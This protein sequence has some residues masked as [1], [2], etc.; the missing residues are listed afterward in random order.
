VT[1]RRALAWTVA[2]ALPIAL[3]AASC[4][5]VPPVAPPQPPPQRPAP[6]PTPAPRET[7]PPAPQAQPAFRLDGEPEIEV[8]IGVDQDRVRI[9]PIRTVR[10]SKGVVTS[11]DELGRTSAPFEARTTGSQWVLVWDRAA[12]THLSRDD[13]LWIDDIHASGNEP[14]RADL[15]W[16]GHTWRG[17]FKLFM[18]PRGR[19][20]LVTRLP[21]ESYLIG[22]I[23]GEIGALDERLLDAGRAQAIA[24]R[25]YTLY[26]RGRRGVE[27]FDVYGTVLDQVYGP[28]E[29]EAPAA[30]RCVDD[31]RGEVA[32]YD[33][34]PI[35]ANYCSTC[36]GITAEVWEAWP[37]SGK[38]YLTSHRDWDGVNDYCAVSRHY[39]W[40][41]VWPARLFLNTIERYGPPEGVRMP[42][43]GAGELR[44][45]KVA[46]RSRS[47]RV[48][49][50]I[51]TTTTGEIVIPAYSLRRVLRRP[52]NPGSILRS[53]LFKIGVRHDPRSGRA[54]EVVA[55]GAGSGHGAGLCQVGART[56]AGLG[57]PATGII[58]HYYTGVEVKRLY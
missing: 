25:S 36:G 43:G 54:T 35:R 46:S 7:P 8:G 45:V 23:P 55:N 18:N 51:V 33:G 14:A 20:T 44:D 13:T 58:R 27:G 11:N 39:R 38:A 26:Y 19:L 2:V 42:V 12:M 57:I 32:M 17:R 15:K 40:T 47:G 56:M 30:T 53:T 37:D 9:E 41:E 34:A 31:T 3:A 6:V 28:V 21:L 1:V 4:A 24:A 29:N 5:P 48:W 49:R 22:V 16:D 10:L 50:L 52:D